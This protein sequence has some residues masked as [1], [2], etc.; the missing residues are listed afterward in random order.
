[1]PM[2][3]AVLNST[4]N[5]IA[6]A[7]QGLFIWN[8][9]NQMVINSF[10]RDWQV[11]TAD[12]NPDG[13]LVA[14]VSNRVPNRV[15][16][17]DIATGEMVDSFTSTIGTISL[18]DWS[19]DGQHIAH[20][21]YE[22]EEMVIYLWDVDSRQITQVLRPH[23]RLIPAMAWT[24]DGRY[25]ASGGG[26]EYWD[27]NNF[28]VHVWDITQGTLRHELVGH[29]HLITDLAWH[30]NG[31]M[32][33]ASSSRN[34]D[35]I[36]IWDLDSGRLVQQ[37]NMVNPTRLAWHPSGDLLAVGSGLDSSLSIFCPGAE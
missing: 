24:P 2:T 27:S 21:G 34:D 29:K 9:N 11:L 6:V 23:Q 26:G 16:I 30:P 15:Q 19:P 20:V 1:M 7:M 17:V 28:A 32:L 14:F 25:L 5:N 35:T 10:D 3:A 33:L 4:S 31:D 36:L 18:L 37:Y 8:L 13:T 22:S 12:W